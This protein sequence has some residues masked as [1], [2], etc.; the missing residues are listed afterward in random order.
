VPYDLNLFITAPEWWL[1]S[2][3]G[4]SD[5]GYIAGYGFYESKYQAFLLVP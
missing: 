4:I 1:T 3:E 5:S 2:A